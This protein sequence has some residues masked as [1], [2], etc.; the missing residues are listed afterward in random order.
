MNRGEALTLVQ[1]APL[2][3]V[4]H[5]ALAETYRAM[6]QRC[7][8]H[9]CRRTAAALAGRSVDPA[10]TSWFRPETLDH[11]RHYRMHALRDALLGI[12][13]GEEFSLLDIGGGDGALALFLPRTDYQLM[14]P[15]TNGLGAED[16]PHADDSV[17][18]V[19]ACHVFEHIPPEAREAFLDKLCAVARRHVLLLN[20]FAAVGGNHEE[21]LQITVDLIGASWAREHLECGLPEMQEVTD[22]ATRRGLSCR[23]WPNGSVGTSFLATYVRHYATLAGRAGEADRIDAYLNGLDP[24]LLVSPVLPAA[25]FVHLEL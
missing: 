13:G 16:L 19:C 6:G 20:P 14:E 9:A 23:T 15:G 10:S 24:D 7:A 17:D 11:N 5:D 12:A 2:D 18:I 4:A 25:W 22:F 21:R 1:A 8:A 3:P